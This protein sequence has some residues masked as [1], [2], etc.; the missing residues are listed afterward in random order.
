MIYIL[1]Q[2]SLEKIVYKFIHF[3]H[4]IYDFQFN[5]NLHAFSY[6]LSQLSYFFSLY[7][8]TNY[9]VLPQQMYSLLDAM[10]PCLSCM[11]CQHTA[12]SLMSYLPIVHQY[13]HQQ[14]H[15]H[16]IYFYFLMLVILQG[17]NL[18]NPTV[19]CSYR[20]FTLQPAYL[21]YP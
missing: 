7:R 4:I 16:P 9:Y 1:M 18:L 12:L 10:S 15:F 2:D 21:S 3:G 13:F 8:G 11:T 19:F 6:H 20:I 17:V 14:T 5:F